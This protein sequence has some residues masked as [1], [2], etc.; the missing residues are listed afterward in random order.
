MYRPTVRYDDMYEKYVTNLFNCTELDRNQIIRA[1]LFIAGHTEQFRKII[2]P[3]LKKGMSFPEPLWESDQHE[4]WLNKTVVSHKK[5]VKS[6]P[7]PKSISQQ[8]A[9]SPKVYSPNKN[10]VLLSVGRRQY[11]PR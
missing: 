8:H 10:E 11:A 4:Y 5:A 1:A 3:H 7:R 9:T 6:N 2:A